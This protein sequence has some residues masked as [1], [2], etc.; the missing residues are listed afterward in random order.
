MLQRIGRSDQTDKPWVNFYTITFYSNIFRF[1]NL[2]PFLDDADLL[3]PTEMHWMW[4][5]SSPVN[6]GYDRN[7]RL[8]DMF[9]NKIPYV[10]NY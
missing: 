3:W 6:S 10:I 9:H 4:K 5:R 7:K 2:I 8:R 1:K